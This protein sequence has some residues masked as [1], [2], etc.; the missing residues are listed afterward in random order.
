MAVIAW[1]E[2]V[3]FANIRKFM[4]AYP[5]NL[6]GNNIVFYQS[7]VKLHGSNVAVQVHLDG[8]IICQS[9]TSILTP[10]DDYAGFAKLGLCS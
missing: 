1:T 9:R 10:E 2:I 4:Q 7:K 5:E 6:K 3:G 8:S